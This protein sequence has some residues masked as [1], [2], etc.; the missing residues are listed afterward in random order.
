MTEPRAP[1]PAGRALGL[2]RVVRTAGIL[3]MLSAALPSMVTQGGAVVGEAEREFLVR[4]PDAMPLRS[5]YTLGWQSSPLV[6]WF[7]ET[8]LTAAPAGGISVQRFSGFEVD[9][10]SWSAACLALGSLLLWL[11]RD[12]AG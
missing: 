2:R 12:K 1:E 8:R 7:S 9:L 10:L 5:D 4:H 3:A 11:T 6:R